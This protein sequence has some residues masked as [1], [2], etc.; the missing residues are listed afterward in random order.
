VGHG[1]SGGFRTTGGVLR[2]PRAQLATGRLLIGN[3]GSALGVDRHVLGAAE[4][5]GGDG[6]S[7]LATL[8][9]LGVGYSG[10]SVK[11]RWSFNADLGMMALSPGNSVKLGRVVGGAQS[12]DE[13]LR[14]MRLAP[15]LQFGVSYSF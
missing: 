13:L 5:Y 7:D 10:L 3:P 2:G 9:Y 11:G 14:D 15:M 1:S 8:P 12:L 4:G 6:A